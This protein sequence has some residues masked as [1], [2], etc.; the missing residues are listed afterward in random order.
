LGELR[1]ATSEAVGELTTRNFLQLFSRT[2]F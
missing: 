1:G 2:G